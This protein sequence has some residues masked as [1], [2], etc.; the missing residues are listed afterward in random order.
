MA[1][2]KIKYGLKNV[3]Y[4]IATIDNN[5]AA[6]YG[7]PKAF[8]GAVSLSLAAQGDT[9]PFYADNIVY[10]TGV[11]N[12]GYEGTL[13]MARISDDF[14]QDCLGYLKSN[15]NVLLEDAG[16]EAVHFALLFQFEGD[17]QATRHIMYNCTASRADTGSSTKNESVEPGTETINIR[18]TSIYVSALGTGKDIV[19][20]ESIDG[21]DS[22][23]YGSWFSTVYIPTSIS[24]T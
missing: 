24:T 15:K 6:T 23:T 22:T 7:A 2:N 18:A 16:A 13:E 12:T 10:W 1:A 21:T 17:Q 3:Y 14:K 4:A 20:A 8:P 19:K 11:S 9:T 5:G